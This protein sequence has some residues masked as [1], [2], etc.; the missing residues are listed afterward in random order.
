MRGMVKK[1]FGCVPLVLEG[2]PLVLVG[3]PLVFEGVAIIS[4]NVF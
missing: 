1:G 2:V 4:M 3:V